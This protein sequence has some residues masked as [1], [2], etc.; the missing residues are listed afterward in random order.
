MVNTYTYEIPLN[1]P[2]GLY[3]Y[4]C[5]LHG[6]TAAQVYT[7]LVGLLEVGR[8]DATC[9]SSPKEHSHPQHGSTVDFFFDRAGGLAN[10]TT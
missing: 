8:T 1:M 4:H 6:L 2:Q 5:H 9:R 7:G 3:W 10:S